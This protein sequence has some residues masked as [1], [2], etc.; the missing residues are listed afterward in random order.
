MVYLTNSLPSPLPPLLV[1]HPTSPPVSRRNGAGSPPVPFLS[2][3]RRTKGLRSTHV[4]IPNFG[5]KITTEVQG[6]LE[7]GSRW[8]E[9][10]ISHAKAR[11]REEEGLLFLRVSAPSREAL[12][13]FPSE[14]SRLELIGFAEK[15]G[16][17]HWGCSD[18]LRRPISRLSSNRREIPRIWGK[19]LAAT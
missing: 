9:L 5:E 12:L 17:R 14:Q 3:G 18:G 13:N 8:S 6:Q 16:H 1:S 7:D 2:F 15:P 19:R 10:G 11:S 4:C